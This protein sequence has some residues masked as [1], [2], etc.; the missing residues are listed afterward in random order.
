VST[1]RPVTRTNHR[2]PWSRQ[3]DVL[4]VSIDE[5]ATAVI[6]R[7]VARLR[8][9]RGADRGVRV[10][11]CP[12]APLQDFAGLSRNWCKTHERKVGDSACCSQIG[13]QFQRV[14]LASP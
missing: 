11:I 9:Q 8:L 1:L 2:Q 7:G 6:V 5:L 10:A 3:T 14:A 4:E 12:T 13:A